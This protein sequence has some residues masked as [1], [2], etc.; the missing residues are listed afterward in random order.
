MRLPA[1]LWQNSALLP[2]KSSS[3]ILYGLAIIFSV[4]CYHWRILLTGQFSL[5][6]DWEGVNQAYVWYH[7]W[8]H[9]IRSGIVPLWDPYTYFGHTF[10]GEMQT[11]SFYPLNLL[12][13]LLPTNHLGIY[14]AASYHYFF[15]FAHLLAVV[16]MYLLV[17]WLGCSR[18]AALVGGLA[19][20]FAG[21]VSKM[22]WPHM[23]HSAIWLPLIL[24]FVLKALR[25]R[26]WPDAV[27]Y[28]SLA[29]LILGMATLAGGLHVVIMEAMVVAS[30]ALFLVPVDASSRYRTYRHA[31]LVV[32]TVGLFAFSIA[33]VQLLPSAEY[34][35][36]SIRFLGPISLPPNE[37]IPYDHMSDGM[38]P[39]GLVT[40]FFPYAFHGNAGHG[41]VT[42][43]YMG[44]MILL[45]AVIGVWKSW[46]RPLVKYL[47]ALAI[48]SLVYA[49]GGYTPLHG[50]L[51]AMV[52]K[53]WIAREAG[54]FVFLSSFAIAILAA[55][56]TDSLFY[57]QRKT[58]WNKL[59]PILR[60]IALAVLAV[61]IVPALFPKFLELHPHLGFS[62]IVIL[63]SLA[64]LAYICKSGAT[65]AAKVLLVA[66][67]LF[68]INYFD[69][70]PRNKAEIAR[71]STNHLD[72]LRS[73]DGVATYL[74]T[75]PGEFRVHVDTD[76]PPNIA[77]LYQI[78]AVRGNGATMH[79]QYQRMYGHFDLMNVRYTIR[80]ASASEPNPLYEDLYWKVY[81]RP[82]AFP[83]A[84]LVNRVQL[85]ASETEEFEL[86]N[87]IDLK[88]TAVTQEPLGTMSD[89]SE[90][91]PRSV[92]FLR[93][94]PHEVELSVVSGGQALLVVGD[95][96]YNGWT[97]TVDGKP[98]A[99]HRVDGA[100][101][102]IVIQGGKSTVRMMYAPRS[103][104]IGIVLL[105]LGVSGVIAL[106]IMLVR[107][108][109]RYRPNAC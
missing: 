78:Q 56:G 67:I 65:T 16:N 80:P 51:Y 93:Y 17:R 41:E 54:R 90:Q 3:R 88:A 14:S 58:E 37:K 99:I 43:P 2:Q 45:L 35:Q 64:A 101:R 74:K 107:H 34:S 105:L 76:D 106:F 27:A 42:N 46:H 15:A 60:R 75:L 22:G 13:L 11:G 49:L 62:M 47:V 77:N 89:A 6:T 91:D 84:W 83:R 33:A 9:A 104:T 4:V 21:F 24:L 25:V 53:L 100:L 19:F 30:A 66:V 7:Y 109:K 8:V 98:A 68:D 31:I 85:A 70:L 95:M 48:V 94:T 96:F 61:L 40:L 86:L 55:Y 5:L 26:I 102:G 44:V 73:M 28:S 18:I 103:V 29:G 12:W 39:Q 79:N 71:S 69:W 23:L 20:S 50:W 38:F 97:A 57:T 72:R 92:Q 52:P 82:G 32:A 87:T 81:E 108:D 63:G 59:Y 1:S 10:I 36:Q